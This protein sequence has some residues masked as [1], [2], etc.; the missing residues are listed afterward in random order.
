M[1]T[2]Y[3]FPA[4]RDLPSLSPFCL[5]VETYLKMA[6]IDYENEFV[7][8]P[9]KAPKGKLPYVSDGSLVVAD[10]TLILDHLD[11]IYSPKFGIELSD[12]EKRLS[13]FIETSV[14][15]Y[16]S[17]AILWA[18]WATE[19]GWNK[20]QPLFFG[21]LP[22]HMKLWLPRVVRKKM[23]RDL[24]AQGLARHSQAELKEIFHKYFTLLADCLGDKPY[25]FGEEPTRL[26]ATVFS[27]L[28]NIYRFPIEGL[29]LDTANQYPSLKSYTDRMMQRV[30]D[31]YM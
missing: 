22:W 12:E 30:W 3:Q 27:F 9:A 19:P 17:W 23:N 20:L 10:S 16:L 5:R 8:N 25:F 15:E 6:G 31:G 7:R 28:G 11:R 18:R 26:D 21:S 24:S 14:N 13:A 29:L 4:A 2:L 1:I